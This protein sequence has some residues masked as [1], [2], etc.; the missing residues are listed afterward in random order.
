MPYRPVLDLRR[1]SQRVARR[2]VVRRA[3]DGEPPGPVEA[4]GVQARKPLPGE[5]GEDPAGVLLEIGLEP[6]G[7]GAV[8]ACRSPRAAL[9]V[10]H[11]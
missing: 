2:P 3:L 11:G 4:R 8:L 1:E 10:P 6:R 7:I 9:D 5:R